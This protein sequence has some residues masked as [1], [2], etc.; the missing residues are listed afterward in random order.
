MLA[1]SRRLRAD[2][3]YALPA[4]LGIGVVMSLIITVALSVTLS[5]VQK[6]TTE[7][8]WNAA[9][10]A[11]YA[12]IE[13]YKSRVENDL[14]YS[15]YG[16]P[17]SDFTPGTAI[18]PPD[19]NPAFNVGEGDDWATVPGS[20]G[21]A[22][23][24]Y[25]VDT[26]FLAARGVVRVRATGK[27]GEQ[28]RSV[29]ADL[30]QGGFSDYV[31][32]TD[33]EA[34]HPDITGRSECRDRYA[35]QSR[36]SNCLIQFTSGDVL[37]G[38][39]HSNDRLYINCD[40]RFRGLVT[41][42]AQLPLYATTGGASTCASSTFPGGGPDRVQRIEMPPTNAEM[43]RETRIDIPDIVPEPGCLYTG[44]T[45][46]ILHSNGTMTVYSPW[47][48]FTQISET[49]GIPSRNNAALCG[50]PGTASG[51]LGH[52]GGATI[53]VINDNLLFVQNVPAVSSDPNYWPTSGG[54]SRPSNFTCS[55]ANR[56][57]EG[58]QFGS[59][60]YPYVDGSGRTE[61]TPSTS[62]STRPG[63]G[64]RNGDLFIRGTLSG[65]MTGSAENYVY[66]IGDI[67]YANPNEDVLGLVSQNAVWVWNPVRSSGGSY[68]AMTSANRTI[69]AA[70][71]SVDYTILVQNYDRGTGRGTL[72]I[73]GSMA[74][75][76]R[77][78]VGTGSGSSMTGYLKDYNYD[79][80]LTW[81]SPPKYLTP[82]T[83]TF[84][85]VQI[86]GVP[87]AYTANGA[88]R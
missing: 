58:W 86:A 53:P 65:A 79:A 18:L 15:R 6:A 31:Y 59:W 16:N 22:L 55:D 21:S 29:V 57:N 38:K 88:P 68:V 81:I 24:R 61:A 63:Y 50:Q 7:T 69:S 33:Y 10:V 46:V 28:T 34:M 45:T 42:A 67:S 26:S 56:A 5:G 35:W 32:Y 72:T 52:T 14:S 27:V 9:L 25:E 64:C 49:G 71:L 51:Q 87:S 77:G 47:T 70:M 78:P 30:R 85:I 62:H 82:S 17:A 76:Y 3:G 36:S 20:D 80:K 84:G 1:L 11:A 12:G 60:R 75:K 41:S 37:N 2:S 83:T 23:F 54:S 39:V 44:P 48:K 66:V 13:D 4:V 74:Q 19:D 8:H 40:A 73:I 43:R